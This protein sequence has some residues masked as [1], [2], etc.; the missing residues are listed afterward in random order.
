MK[1]LRKLKSSIG[2]HWWGI[3]VLNSNPPGRKGFACP[4]AGRFCEAVKSAG[5]KKVLLDPDRFMCL[6]SRYAFGCRPDPKEQMI[7]KLA[8]EKGF[9]LTYAAK[10]IEGT[11][12]FQIQPGAIGVNMGDQPQLLLAQL[13]PEQAMRLI[14]LYQKKMQKTYRTEIAA[15][16]TACANVTVK[17]L[18][19]Q[20]MVISFGCNDSRAYGGLTRNRLYA[21]VPYTLAVELIR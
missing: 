12:H 2:G 20:D 11:P 1:T 17:A 14:Q 5:G 4:Q 9:P 3:S 10:L 18:Q 13:Q 16:I 8:E 7:K 6:G 15:V 21:G 19:S